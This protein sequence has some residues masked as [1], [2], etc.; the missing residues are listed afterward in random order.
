VL[1]I[2]I[3]ARSNRKNETGAGTDKNTISGAIGRPRGLGMLVDNA[4]TPIDS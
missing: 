1:G 4:E 3:W 2:R